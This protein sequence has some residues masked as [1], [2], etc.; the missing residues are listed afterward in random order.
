MSSQ[1][2]VTD[3]FDAAKAIVGAIEGLDKQLQAQAIRFACEK[4][5]LGT[6]SFSQVS[7]ASPPATSPALTPPGTGGVQ[8]PTTDIKQFTA[9]KAP[10]SDQQFVAVVAYYY[11]FVAPE[12]QRRDT[13]NAQTLT[14]AARGVWEQNPKW[15]MI[16]TNAKNAGYLDPA[17][18]GEYRL[19]A[20]GE[21]LVAMTL[22]GTSPER[23]AG[24]TS[25]KKK[26]T[27]KKTRRGKRD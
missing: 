25:K 19:S 20:V 22:P 6:P 13:I 18:R 27:K 17:D 15:G 4:L 1:P 12:A 2:P 16:L 14:S 5:G 24:R 8:T 10:K 21:N 23:R 3:V 11:R 26:M 7:S 9:S